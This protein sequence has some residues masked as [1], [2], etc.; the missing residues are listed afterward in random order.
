M[1]GRRRLAHGA[2]L[3]WLRWAP[4]IA[5]LVAFDRLDGTRAVATGTV[6]AL[7]AAL[8]CVWA[9]RR[10]TGGSV[11]PS[12][13]AGWLE[14]ALVWS[15]ITALIAAQAATGNPGGL[16]GRIATVAIALGIAATA[17]ESIES[18][19]TEPARA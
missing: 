17:A 11:A 16:A 3:R 7:A 10:L 6:V 9:Q 15:S 8:P 13:V 4:L 14:M 19:R 18:R 12:P 2:A 5:G 1:S